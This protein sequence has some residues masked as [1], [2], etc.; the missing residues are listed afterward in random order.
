M[1]TR[2]IDRFI[3]TPYFGSMESPTTITTPRLRLT[4]IT[5]VESGS[6]ALSDLHCVWGNE[7]ATKWNIHGSCKTLSETE[8]RA[9]TI[10]K[11]AQDYFI[12]HRKVPGQH[13]EVAEGK[14]A[15]PSESNYTWEAIGMI[16]LVRSEKPDLDP[17]PIPDS[18]LQRDS[19]DSDESAKLP[20]VQTRSIGYMYREEA[21]GKGYGMEA[22]AALL[23]HFRQAASR[24]DSP[25]LVYVEAG[26]DP[27]NTGSLRILEKLRFQKVG[28]NVIADEKVFLAGEW[29]QNEYPIYGLYL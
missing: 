19:Q 3:Y 23:N 28:L 20:A 6:I 22:A 1:L 7:I 29:R 14:D 2:T 12:V 13:L 5:G 21:W 18:K 4:H 11:K 15:A 8:E 9:R 27:S 17:L 25:T 10:L 24:M 26:V 16:N